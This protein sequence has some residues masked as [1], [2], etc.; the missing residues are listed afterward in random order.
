MKKKNTPCINKKEQTESEDNLKMPSLKTLDF[1]K[2][3]ARVYHV[4]SQKHAELCS[5]VIN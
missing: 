1:L 5:F 2:Q 3:F 4:G